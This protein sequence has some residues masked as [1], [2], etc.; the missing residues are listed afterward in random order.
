MS[1]LITHS[2]MAWL[3][4]VNFQPYKD[5]GDT[6]WLNLDG[7][8]IV[9]EKD[10]TSPFPPSSDLLWR[11]GVAFNLDTAWL[12]ARGRGSNFDC[13]RGLGPT[14]GEALANL[15][16]NLKAY[17]DSLKPSLWSRICRWFSF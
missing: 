2:E 11:A 17:S 5:Y 10:T 4:R 14:P 12:I 15:N 8:Y 3:A 6:F 13:Y 16:T 1:K 9:L 7:S